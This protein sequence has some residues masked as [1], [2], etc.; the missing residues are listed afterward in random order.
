MVVGYK[1]QRGAAEIVGSG[2]GWLIRDVVDAVKYR[3]V[4][5]KPR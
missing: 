2:D 1:K 3:N 4:R 5:R